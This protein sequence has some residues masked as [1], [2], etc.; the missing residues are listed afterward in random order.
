MAGELTHSSITPVSD[1][2]DGTTL[3]TRFSL[4]EDCVT[5]GVDEKQLLTRVHVDQVQGPLRIRL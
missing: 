2:F 1:L 5:G 3:E 4:V